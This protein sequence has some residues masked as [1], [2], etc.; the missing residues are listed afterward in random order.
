MR[1]L[2]KNNSSLNKQFRV[3]YKTSSKIVY[4]ENIQNFLFYWLKFIKYV[5]KKQFIVRPIY[6]IFFD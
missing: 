5:I 3:F 4:N 1:F 2:Y 6:N